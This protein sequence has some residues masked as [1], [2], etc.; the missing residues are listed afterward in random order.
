MWFLRKRNGECWKITQEHNEPYIGK[1]VR[2]ENYN[3][4]YHY[5]KIV[6]QD[7]IFSS[8]WETVLYNYY[9]N[10]QKSEYGWLNREGQF[11][12][13]DKYDHAQCI[14][15]ISGMYEQDAE[16]VG[17]IKIYYDPSM[18]SARDDGICWYIKDIRRITHEQKDELLMRGFNV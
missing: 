4:G 2:L 3:G 6:E 17:W 1:L 9:K 12:G 18:P 10:N 11:F 16:K 7:E 15:N 8:D 5:Y 13:C 14:Y